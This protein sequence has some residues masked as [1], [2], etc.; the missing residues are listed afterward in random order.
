MSRLRPLF[1]LVLVLVATVLVACSDPQVKVPTTYSPEKI[2][3]LQV[4]AKPLNIARERLDNVQSLISEQNWVDT[5]T[6]IHGPLGQLRQDTLRMSRALLPK[7]QKT[8]KQIAQ[9]L[10]GDLERIDSAAKERNLS[11]AKIQYQE[12]LDDFDAFLSLILP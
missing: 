2:A 6:Y 8:A 7:D 1:S 5:Q 10:F 11:Q 12:A 9:K 3:Q 4:Y